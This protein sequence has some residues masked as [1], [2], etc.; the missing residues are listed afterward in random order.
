M[1]ASENIRVT[2]QLANAAEAFVGALAALFPGDTF[3]QL[4]H[5]DTV[6]RA[7][8]AALQQAIDSYTSPDTLPLASGLMN[9]QVLADARVVSE[10]LKL[11]L[12]DQAPDYR[13]VIEHW[14]ASIPGAARTLLAREAPRFFMLLSHELRQSA[15][16]R[17]VLNQIAEARFIA[18]EE[19][20]A[21]DRADLT[22]LLESALLA[23]P[24]MLS[25][26]VKPL[27]ALTEAGDTSSGEPVSLLALANLADYLPTETLQQLWERSHALTD[28]ALRLQILVR[29]APRLGQIGLSTDPLSMV[30]RVVDSGPVDPLVVVDTLLTL[31]P[32]LEVPSQESALPSFQQRVLAGAQSI[33]DAASRVRALGALIE[34]LPPELQY[35]AVSAAFE[36]ASCCVP[37]DQARA[38]ALGVLPPHLPPDFHTRL[39]TIASEIETP[40]ARTLLFGRMI[41]YLAPSLQRQA[42][43]GALQAIEELSGDEAR[44][45]AL[46]TL[47]PHIDA[48]GPL[49][50]I[51][52]GLQQAIKVIFSIEVDDDRARAFAA[53]APYLSPELLAEALQAIK[54]IQDDEDRAL[55]LIKLSSHLSDELNV[56]AFGIAQEIQTSEARAAALSALAPYLSPTA[57]AQAL[58]DA[59]AAALSIGGRYER[60]VAL[61]DLAPHLPDDLKLRALHEALTATR[62][63]PVEDERGRALVFL[64]PHLTTPQLPDALADVYTILD[65][66]ARIP[67]LSALLPYLPDQPRYRATKDVIEMAAN[68]S[69]A[70]IKASILAAVAPVMPDELVDAAAEVALQIETPYDRL[71]VLT[72]LLPRHP[73]R[74]RNAALDAARA[75]PD[76]YQRVSALLELV[77]HTAQRYAILDEALETALTVED[78]YDRA[79]AIAHLAPYVDWQSDAQNRQQ[80]A[81]RLALK[82]CL[83]IV[84][85]Q[86]RAGALR[87]LA[88]DVVRLLPPAQVYPLWREMVSFLRGQPYA[89][90]L[91]DLAALAPLLDYI[92]LPGASDATDELV[93]ALAAAVLGS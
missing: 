43:T 79:S 60:V 33:T 13:V 57:R 73:E 30:Q 32:H 38:A 91:S 52:E 17:L 80:D 65:P 77:P 78:D 72:A 53:L 12:P 24:T 25:R 82:A 92:T 5:G 76:R 87:R 21:A 44:T 36:T 66:M 68:A 3:D 59:L 23:G 34:K 93:T 26:Q 11:F 54:N 6:R 29:M 8:W 81:L 85:V 16:L 20:R 75:V 22:R 2:Q 64:A 88:V 37:S 4:F 48:L 27:L 19:E 70:Y 10:L 41:P 83:G 46:I 61:V 35:E 40:E 39:M 42:L 7:Y 74:L 18:S 55:A 51:P 47:A 49:Q 84:D 90:M 56:A 89:A 14:A 63:I 45:R 67:A 1:T 58:A 69:P 31:A 15:D 9:G 86:Q 28:R 50:H 62:S 71:H